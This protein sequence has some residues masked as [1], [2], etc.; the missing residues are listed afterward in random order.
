MKAPHEHAKLVGLVRWIDENTSGIELPGDE[1]SIL[2]IGC[3]DVALEHQAAIALLHSSELYGSA[4]A[5]LRCETESLVRG[6]WLLHAASLEDIER[7]RCGKVKQEFRELIDMLESKINQRSGILSGLRDRAWKAMN[8]FTHTGFVQVS[9]R[10]RPGHVCENYPEA[11]LAQ[12]LDL[13][14]ALGLVAAGQ[15]VEMSHDK[16]RLP[17][18]AE[19]MKAYVVKHAAN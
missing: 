17:Q 15:L 18:Y 4:L 5:L 19:K 14:G 12:A 9:R 1:R 10:H 8:D 11:E 7:F 6:L 2:A 13:A 3:L 16:E